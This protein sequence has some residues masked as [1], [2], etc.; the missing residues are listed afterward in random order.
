MKVNRL[1]LEVFG[2]A[3]STH[4]HHLTARAP[5]IK[6]VKAGRG[7]HEEIGVGKEKE[8]PEEIQYLVH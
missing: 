8:L 5:H 3:S 2:K 6:F 4:L 7:E 1:G